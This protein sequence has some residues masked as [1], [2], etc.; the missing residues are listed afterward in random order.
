MVKFWYCFVP[1]NK[2]II[3]RGIADLA[4][5]RIEPH[6][7]NYMGKVFEDICRQYL[8]KLLLK[9]KSPVEFGNL[10]RWWGTDPS[11]RCQ[12]EIDI[13]GE[14][15]K[16]TAFFAECKWTTERVDLN[17][18][19]T[20]AYRS[21]LFH[22]NNTHLYLFAKNGFTKGCEEAATKMGNVSLVTYDDILDCLL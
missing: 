20:L 3:V 1:A 7:S 4:Y 10:G 5:K 2:S 8:W 12:M 21:K 22:Y 13:M 17:V 18:L 11:T 6:L 19:E 14:Q 9:E 15:D 16:D